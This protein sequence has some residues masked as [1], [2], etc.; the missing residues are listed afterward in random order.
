VERGEKT[1]EADTQTCEST[2]GEQPKGDDNG[3]RYEGGGGGGGGGGGD[4]STH[5]RMSS[6]VI[7]TALGSDIARWLA[8]RR[9]SNEHHLVFFLRKMNGSV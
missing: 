1:A 4:T 2:L 8:S 3:S 9:F 5:W 7:M 6:I